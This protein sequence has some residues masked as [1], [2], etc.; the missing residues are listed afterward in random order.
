M[1]RNVFRQLA[2]A[3]H[4]DRESDPDERDRKTAL[5]SEANAAYANLDALGRA[6]RFH[7]IV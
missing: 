3:V 1:L 6:Y 2:S 7:V 4:P 5:M